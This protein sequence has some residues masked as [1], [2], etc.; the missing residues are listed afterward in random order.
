VALSF[1]RLKYLHL[2]IDP[3]WVNMPAACWSIAETVSGITCACLPT[4]RPLVSGYFPQLSASST[5]VGDVDEPRKGG[6]TSTET[7][8]NREVS[9]EKGALY[10]STSAL[11]PRAKGLQ[12]E[13]EDDSDGEVLGLGSAR[14][15]L[16][17]R[18]RAGLP[19]G[20]VDQA[21]LGLRPSVK[22]EIARSRP[23]SAQRAPSANSVHVQ[24][25]VHLVNQE[26][27]SSRGSQV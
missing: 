11:S 8:E 5:E 3:T 4:F 21:V 20:D 25:E 16:G 27:R 18:G 12:P 10:Q 17:S 1:A 15:G 13:T 26:R 24:K 23:Q 6:A 22:T 7:T 9:V 14:E 2:D 19:P